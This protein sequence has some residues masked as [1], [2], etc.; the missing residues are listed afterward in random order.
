MSHH[1]LRV[2]LPMFGAILVGAYLLSHVQQERFVQ[3]DR[4][5]DPE[6]QEAKRKAAESTLENELER[7]TAQLKLDEWKQVR[8]SREGAI[9]WDSEESDVEDTA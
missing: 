7:M 9:G 8:V 3:G 2:G 6:Y 1:F 4:E 5:R